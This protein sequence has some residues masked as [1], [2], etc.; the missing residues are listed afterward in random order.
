MAALL[1]T[2]FCGVK[3]VVVLTFKK[4]RREFVPQRLT[5]YAL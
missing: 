3:H 4:G 2:L 5:N 1:Y